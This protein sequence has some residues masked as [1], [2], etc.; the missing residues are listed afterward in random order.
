MPTQTS[1]QRGIF[2]DVPKHARYLRYT[3]SRQATPADLR[4][5]VQ[6][7][8]ALVDGEQVV[9]GLGPALMQDLSP[10]AAAKMPGLHDFTAPA[11]SKVAWPH[12]PADLWLW[13]RAAPGQDLG[14]LL[15]L[16]QQLHS[17]LHPAFEL[18][19]AVDAFRH[20]D[21]GDEQAGISRDLT[22]FE[23]GTENPKGRK[24][25][26]AAFAAH[27]SSF[28]AIQLWQH[29][30]ARIH[31]M[32]AHDQSQAMGRD[33]ASNEELE[34]APANAHIKRTTQEDFTLSDGSEGFSWRRSMPWVAGDASGLHFV[35]FGKSFEAF[36]L[37][38]ARMSGVDKETKDGITDAVL[39]MSQPLRTSYFWCPPMQASKPGSGR[40][41]QLD[42]SFLQ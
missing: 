8:A 12:S 33:R 30:W 23:D 15:V 39:Q 6:A 24:A 34:D 2:A 28:V 16:S 9:L 37:Q 10:R 13:L 22:G 25:L 3:R 38:L 31:G 7:L 41:K 20:M 42:V 11:G 19:D 29:R 1:H 5:I 40:Q 18:L 26:T 36:E 4:V 14:H 35:S 17:L 32:S 27:G 21:K